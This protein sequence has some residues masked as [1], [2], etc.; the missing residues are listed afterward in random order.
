MLQRQRAV[1]QR[2]RALAPSQERVGGGTELHCA[3][4]VRIEF[5]L[6]IDHLRAALIR[7]A[8]AHAVTE[9]FIHLGQQAAGGEIRRIELDVAFKE[10]RSLREVTRANA[11]RAYQ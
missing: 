11:W 2:E 8:A 5:E 10:P 4:I 7:P 9:R 3:S 6:S 1:G